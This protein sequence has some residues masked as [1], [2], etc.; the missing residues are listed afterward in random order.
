MVRKNLVIYFVSKVGK[1][2]A[3]LLTKGPLF[4]QSQL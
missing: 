3:G 1:Q 2:R 4:L